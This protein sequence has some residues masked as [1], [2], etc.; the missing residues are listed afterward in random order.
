M[1]KTQWWKIC[2]EF[3]W[4]G[5][6]FFLGVSQQFQQHNHTFTQVVVMNTWEATRRV[7]LLFHFRACGDHCEAVKA[8]LS[9]FAWDTTNLSIKKKSQRLWFVTAMLRLIFLLFNK[10]ALAY[11][12][13]GHMNS[14]EFP[15]IKPILILNPYFVLLWALSTDYPLS[16]LES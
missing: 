16:R 1:I 12:F 15:S 5:I 13:L 2:Q 14:Y 7:S 11:L 6:L 4:H 3:D 10:M 9:S 8:L